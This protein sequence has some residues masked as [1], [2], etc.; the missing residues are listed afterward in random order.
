[1]KI[2]KIRINVTKDE[3]ILL[4]ACTAI[5]CEHYFK[6][7]EPALSIKVSELNKKLN[8]EYVKNAKI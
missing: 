2:K 1:M 7:N 4:A 6:D 8:S 3:L 5:A